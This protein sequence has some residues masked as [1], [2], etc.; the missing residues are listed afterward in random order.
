MIKINKEKDRGRGDFGWLK[1]NYSFSFSS[2]VNPQ[3]TNFN[4]LK[5]MNEDFIQPE[6]G[7]PTHGHKD[8]EILTVV[9][10]G[11]LGHTD[12]LG[13]IQELRPGRIQRMYA[14][15]GITHSEFNLSKTEVLNL[16]QIWIEP[17]QK[18]LAPEYNEKEF[19]F[20][21]K[22]GQLLLSPTGRDESIRI[23]QN[24]EVFIFNFEKENIDLELN[25]KEAYIHIVEGELKVEE[26]IIEYGDSLEVKN[27]DVLS[28]RG[29][30]E[31]K[32][33]VFKFL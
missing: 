26:E 4:S 12:S 3:K 17:N 14:G 5:V 15:S 31:G 28:L 24:V 16:M 18:G 10:K 6:A 29:I 2:Y 25:E 33:L 30:K 20:N 8:M 32:L 27:K 7:F 11:V 22:G 23:Y 13:N 19:E 21:K 9:F 1:A